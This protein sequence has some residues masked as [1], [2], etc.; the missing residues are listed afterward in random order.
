MTREQAIALGM[1]AWNAMPPSQ[2][3][4]LKAQLRTKALALLAARKTN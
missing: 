3:A 1:A 4:R 2:Y